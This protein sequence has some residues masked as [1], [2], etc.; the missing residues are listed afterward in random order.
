MATRLA[1]TKVFFLSISTFL[2]VSE[3]T[4]PNEF[5]LFII[6]GGFVIYGGKVE[7]GSLSNEL[8]HYDVFKRV[9]S[10]R[11]KNS[12]FYPPRLTRH[13][14]TLVNE[15]IYLFGGSTVDGEFSSNLYKISL[16]LCMHIFLYLIKILSS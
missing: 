2:T 16:N 6:S 12:P 13:S 9:W 8:W 15:E 1:D 7:D 4:I 10:L 5:K 11:A 3:S 14:L